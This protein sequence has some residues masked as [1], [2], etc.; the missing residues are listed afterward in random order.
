MPGTAADRRCSPMAGR[1]GP[2]RWRAV[3]SEDVVYQA[4]LDRRIQPPPKAD[5]GALGFAF[6][7]SEYAPCAER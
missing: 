1:D 4:A 6:K 7:S 5:L 2:L 3:P